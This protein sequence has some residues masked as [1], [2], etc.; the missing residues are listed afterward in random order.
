MNLNHLP[1]DQQLRFARKK[2]VS[3]KVLPIPAVRAT[4]L[5]KDQNHSKQ[6]QLQLWI[7]T[8]QTSL[9]FILLARFFS[10]MYSIIS[11]CDEGTLLS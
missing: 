7:P 5:L 6:Q 2:P 1:A 4:L 10:G 11:D 9:R 8:F 3:S